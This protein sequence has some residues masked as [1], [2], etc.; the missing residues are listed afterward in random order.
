LP[1]AGNVGPAAMTEGRPW[2]GWAMGSGL[3]DSFAW[4]CRR[5]WTRLFDFGSGL[6]GRRPDALVTMRIADMSRMH[7]AQDD[8]HVCAECGHGVGVY[9]SGQA[10]LRKWP[11]MKVIC[12]ICAFNRPGHEIENMAAADFDTI[13]QESRDSV[14]VGRS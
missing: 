7:P 1:A 4:F 6:M 12:S 2:I 3:S 10:A 8:S 14:D 13:M 11:R 9:P 5:G